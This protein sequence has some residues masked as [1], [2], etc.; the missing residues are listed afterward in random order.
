MTEETW[1]NAFEIINAVTPYARIDLAGTVGEPTLNTELVRFLKIARELA[2]NVQMQIT[3]NGTRILAREFAMKEL[4]DAGANIIYV[5]QYGKHERFEQLAS[6][7]GYPWYQYY[8]KPEGAP[9]PWKYWGPDFKII[10]L[11]NEPSSWP[12]SRQRANLLGSWLGTIDYERAHKA[13]FTMIKKLEEPL[14]RRCN[15]PFQY[16]TVSASGDYL[17]CCQDGLQITRGQ[18]G[19]VNEGLDGFYRFWYGKDMQW[20]RGRLREKDR[21][22]IKEC[23]QCN[24]TFSRSD[25][26]LWSDED[27]TRIYENGQWTNANGD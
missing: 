12:K 15:Q 14:Q 9:S 26:K 6:E 8:D 23:S 22:S 17:L 5:D 1:T 3:T 21:G 11:M 20:I 18:F 7:S 19:N 27:V 4:L 10:V 16:V 2:P 24:I 25:Y 13:G